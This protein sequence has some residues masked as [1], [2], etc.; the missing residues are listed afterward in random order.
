MEKLPPRK[1]FRQLLEKPGYFPAPGVWDPFTARVCEALGIQCVHLGGYQMGVSAR[2]TIK[3]SSMWCRVPN[4]S[5]RS[6]RR[7][8]PA[9]IRIS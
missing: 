9:R 5:T 2:M 1:K 3:A 8:R 7:S 4:C 6:K